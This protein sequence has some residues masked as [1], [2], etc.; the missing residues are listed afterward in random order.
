MTEEEFNNLP[1]E[2]RSR[3][4]SSHKTK[5]NNIV[6]VKFTLNRKYDIA[7]ISILCDYIPTLSKYH[8]TNFIRECIY[9]G[10]QNIIEHKSTEETCYEYLS[11]QF[12]KRNLAREH[13]CMQIIKKAWEV[14]SKKYAPKEPDSV[15]EASSEANTVSLETVSVSLS[16]PSSAQEPEEL[17]SA[18]VSDPDDEILDLNNNPT[19]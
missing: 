18:D 17:L 12:A 19:F 2:E 6:P 9:I 8:K 15:S 3:I 14:D 13:H 10:L 11:S 16:T 1:A 5:E 7:L 4:L